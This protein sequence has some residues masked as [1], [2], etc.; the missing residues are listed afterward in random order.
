MISR[1]VIEK[2]HNLYDY[3]IQIPDEQRVSIITGPNGYGKTTLL[4]IISYLLACKFWFFYFLKFKSI[5]IYFQNEDR[6]II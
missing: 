3:D 2:L 6:N 4:K 5:T 1:I